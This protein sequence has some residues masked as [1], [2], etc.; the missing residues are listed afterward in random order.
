MEDRITKEVKFQYDE[1]SGRIM[2]EFMEGNDRKSWKWLTAEEYYGLEDWLTPLPKTYE[3]GQFYADVSANACFDTN[4]EPTNFEDL[5][6]EL[7]K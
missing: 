7:V 3:A 5:L 6:Y 4:G 2:A 1:P